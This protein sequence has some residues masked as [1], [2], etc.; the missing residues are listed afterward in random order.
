M[1]QQEIWDF[2][3]GKYEKLWVQ[4]RSLAPTRKLVV[5]EVKK[6]L[7]NGKCGKEIS[8]LDVG[9]GTGQLAEDLEE[10]QKPWRVAVTGVDYSPKMIELARR[11]KL[12]KARFV[13]GN[14]EDLPFGRRRFDLVTCC[15]S[16]PYYH[17]QVIALREF[18]RVLKPG[19]LIFLVHASRNNAYDKFILP[20]VKL[21]T[22]RASYPSAATTAVLFKQAGIVCLEQ[23]KLQTGFYMPTILLSIGKGTDR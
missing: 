10:I 19:G 13:Y 2:W 3:A 5:A 1:S 20:F 9:C 7:L 12:F 22:G 23:K 4:K 15:H 16:L 11:K 8:L 18:A 21:T 14:A 6:F 17:N